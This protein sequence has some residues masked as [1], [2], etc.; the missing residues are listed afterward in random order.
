[1]V[2]PHFPRMASPVANRIKEPPEPP[3]TASGGWCRRCGAMHSLPLGQA[4]EACLQLMAQLSRHQR[5]DFAV[6]EEKADPHCSTRNLFGEAG[7]KMFGMLSCRD[8]QGD[9]VML[10]AF[11]GQYNGLWQVD[12][13]VGPVFDVPAFE[14]LILTPEQE[15]KRIGREMAPLAKG[16]SRYCQ[17]LL[18]RRILSRHLM[19]DIHNLYRL[20]NFRGETA[21]LTTA[22]IGAGAPPSGTADCCGPKLLHY[23]ATRGLRPEA[24]AEF[25]WGASNVSSTRLQGRLYPACAAKCQPILGFMLCGVQP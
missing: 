11:S 6:P 19:R 5:I 13:W 20:V 4:R 9:R 17:L 21:S 22:F 23:A 14:G 16:S 15:I 25:Y 1:M 18:Q 3:L 7:G 10:Q 8:G 24:M 12:G 2:V